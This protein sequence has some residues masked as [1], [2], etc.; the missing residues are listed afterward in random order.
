MAVKVHKLVQ[1]EGLDI[2]LI[3]PRPGRIAQGG[4]TGVSDQGPGIPANDRKRLWEP[5]VRLGKD[6]GTT[7]GSGIGL[8]VVRGLV[9]KQAKVTQLESL[10]ERVSGRFTIT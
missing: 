9:E 1:L 7:G 10:G 2:H 6:A 4:E 3:G 5:F 8:A